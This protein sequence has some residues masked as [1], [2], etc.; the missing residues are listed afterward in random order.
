MTFII[1]FNVD[2]YFFVNLLEYSNNSYITFSV[3]FYFW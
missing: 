3:D 2:L 1:T